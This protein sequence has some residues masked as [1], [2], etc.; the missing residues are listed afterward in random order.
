MKA[1]TLY[2]LIV[3]SCLHLSSGSA[4]AQQK[5]TLPRPAIESN[6][7]A[8]QLFASAEG[9]FAALFPGSPT[10]SGQVLKTGVGSLPSFSVELKTGL[11]EYLVSY[12]NFPNA[13]DDPAA[14]KAAYDGGRDA[15][16]SSHQLT[17]VAEREVTLNGY[18]GRHTTAAGKDQLLNNRVFAV[19]KRL[20]QVTIVTRD[21]RKLPP[22]RIKLFESTIN[23]F[24][25]SFRLIPTVVGSNTDLAEKK[26]ETGSVDLGRI[27]NSV[28]IN[29]Y[30]KFRVTLPQTWTVVERDENDAALEVGKELI[31]GSDVATNAAIDQSVS[32]TRVLFIISK[33]PLRTPNVAQA[34][35]QAGIEDVTDIGMTARV[36]LEKNWEILQ[37]SPFQAK[38]LKAVHPVTIAG[39][40]FYKMDVEQTAAGVTIKQKY[41][42]TM[43][44][45]QALFF[46]TNYLDDADNILM[47]KILYSM[48]FQ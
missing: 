6:A 42:A 13:F 32:R 30:F 34:M 7:D 2:A 35:L 44:R 37:G 11:A 12:M 40:S 48:E 38:L 25:D 1:K 4:V 24:L 16:L 18:I 21:F 31:K 8:W 33:F 23:K 3:F 29:E 27:E 22:A 41:F 5:R 46:I 17:L 36:Y 20:Y 19:G 39:I 10:K 47:E 14:L 9:G 28:Y 45:G 15:T 43:R 26:Q